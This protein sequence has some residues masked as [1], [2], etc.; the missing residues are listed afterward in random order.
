MKESIFHLPLY[1]INVG[2][3][4]MH[5]MCHSHSMLMVKAYNILDILSWSRSSVQTNHVWNRWDIILMIWI[6]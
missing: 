1:F 5:A 2:F 3:E 4:L 6:F